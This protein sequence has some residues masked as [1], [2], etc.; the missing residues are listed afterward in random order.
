[1]VL[2]DGNGTPLGIHVD[3]AS[4]AEVKLLKTALDKVSAGRR[5]KAGRPRKRPDRLIM[6]R[7]YDSNPLRKELANPESRV[8]S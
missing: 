5:S 2:V 6:D 4:P 3:S 1:M 7:A 8:P